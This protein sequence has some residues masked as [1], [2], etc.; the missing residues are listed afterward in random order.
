MQT[1]WSNILTLMRS[2]GM[3]AIKSLLT[4]SRDTASI[5]Y[6]KYIIVIFNISSLCILNYEKL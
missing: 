3:H 6:H 1:P 2:E 4:A 5:Y